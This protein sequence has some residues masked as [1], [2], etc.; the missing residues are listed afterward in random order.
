MNL[1]IPAWSR[2]P[3]LG[4]FSFYVFTVLIDANY[5]FAT[6][7]LVI[8]LHAATRLVSPAMQRFAIPSA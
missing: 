6:A 2:Y 7:G 4:A 3:A 8:A 5:S 1:R